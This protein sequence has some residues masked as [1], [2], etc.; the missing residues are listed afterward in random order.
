[1]V[2][3]LEKEF[4]LEAVPC[5]NER[6]ANRV[7]EEHGIKTTVSDRRA[8]TIKQKHH[9]SGLPPVTKKLALAIYEAASDYPTVT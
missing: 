7:R 3:Q 5:S 2:R 1:M 8:L 6:V 9:A 4:G